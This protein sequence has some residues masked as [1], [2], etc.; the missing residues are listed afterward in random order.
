MMDVF[1]ASRLGEVHFDLRAPHADYSA[2][3]LAPAPEPQVYIA[4]CR[5]F[6]TA[7]AR[8]DRRASGM[9]RL[10][11]RNRSTSTAS[12]PAGGCRLGSPGSTSG[13]AKAGLQTPRSRV[14][15]L[16]IV[17]RASPRGWRNT[18]RDRPSTDFNVSLYDVAV[19][20]LAR[21]PTNQKTKKRN[22]QGA[23]GNAE[24]LI[25]RVRVPELL[26]LFL[27]RTRT[28]LIRSG[29]DDGVAAASR[30]RGGPRPRTSSPPPANVGIERVAAFDDALVRTTFAERARSHVDDSRHSVSRATRL[31]HA[32]ALLRSR[33]LQFRVH[34]PARCR[35]LPGR[36]P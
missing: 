31:R 25:S 28:P 22:Y 24:P 34:P 10:S 14:Q 32:R 5:A 30:S 8:R 17:T 29:R 20:C 15:I 23:S 9:N 26:D 35:P 27:A 1:A 11:R 4:G 33:R 21:T 36:R 6:A 3:V 18:S 2:E 19:R 13:S 7:L 16:S 12:T